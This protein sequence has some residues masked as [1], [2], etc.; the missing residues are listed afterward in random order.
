MFSSPSPLKDQLI[1]AG[2][3]PRLLKRFL[4]AWLALSAVAIGNAGADDASGAHR[5]ACGRS[6]LVVVRA[7]ATGRY[8]TAFW[9]GGEVFA[10]GALDRMPLRRMTFRMEPAA[11]GGASVVPRIDVSVG[12]PP[13]L[14]AFLAKI[15]PPKYVEQKAQACE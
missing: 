9:G 1:R 11:G 5:C 8:L 14:L 12:L 6:G 10:I 3:L 4:L 7:E 15:P 13:D 2:S